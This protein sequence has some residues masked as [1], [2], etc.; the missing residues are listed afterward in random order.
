MKV[1]EF[2]FGS[3]GEGVDSSVISGNADYEMEEGSD[4][5]NPIAEQLLYNPK[6]DLAYG[7]GMDP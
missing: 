7:L 3:F 2:L 1:N 6:P 4:L 5:I